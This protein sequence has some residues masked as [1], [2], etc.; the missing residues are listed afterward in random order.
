MEVEVKLCMTVK[1][2]SKSEPVLTSGTGRPRRAGATHSQK[3]APPVVESS[4][5]PTVDESEI[6]RL[7]Y[8]LWQ[9]RGCVGGSP[10]ED[11]LKAQ[12][13]LLKR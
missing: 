7:A 9:E 6:A 8:S 1:R 5:P 2:T 3:T 12:Q 4:E 10:E 11:W 13:E